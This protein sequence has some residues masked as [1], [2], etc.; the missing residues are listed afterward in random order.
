MGRTARDQAVSSGA[1]NGSERKAK[2]AI[3]FDHLARMTFGDRGLER[4]IL[5]LFDTQA[6][7]LIVQMREGGAAAIGPLLH[8]LKGSAAGIGAGQ[9]A[10]AA[11]SAEH[12]KGGDLNR[13][14]DS[15]AR[16]IDDARAAIAVRMT[17]P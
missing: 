14:L 9:V 17:Q 4:E 2:P 3:D 16:E 8:T 10:L 6:A 11:L 15:L 5:Q 13:A 1:D 7:A 12:A